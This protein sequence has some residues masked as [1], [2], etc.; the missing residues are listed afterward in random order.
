MRLE[1]TIA[2]DDRPLRR[3]LRGIEGEV[4]ASSK[5][6]ARD[7]TKLGGEKA[8]DAHVRAHIRELQRREAAE[9][10]AADRTAKYW[11]DAH[12]RAADH[13]IREEARA[14]R[15]R[16]REARRSTRIAAREREELSQ[17]MR[18]GIARTAVGSVGAVARMGGMALGL[19]GG[20]AAAG[21]LDQEL[22]INRR[23]TQLSISAGTPDQ[24]DALKREALAVR[25]FTGAETLSSMQGFVEKT[26]NLSAA[27]AMIQDMG[28]LA[29]ATSTDFGEMGMAAG[30]A[31]NVIRDTITDP[32]EQMK[33][34]NEVMRNLAAG[35][36]M[37]AVEI[38]DMVTELGGLGAAT[39][40]FEGG[41]V[42]LIKQA[43]AMAQASIAR[44]GAGTAP[45]TTTAVTRF[46]QDIVQNQKHFKAAG[47]EIFS[48]KNKTKLLGMEHIAA[49]VLEKTG[50]DLTK[51][52][53]MFGVYG[54][55]ALAGFSP[56]FIEAERKK[57]GSGRAAVAAEFSK[58]TGATLTDQQIKTNVDTRLADPDVQLKEAAKA[59]NTAVGQSLVPVAVDAAHKFAELAPQIGAMA[60]TVAK[61]V[62]FLVENPFA[63]VGVIVGGSIAKDIASAGLANIISGEIK[64]KLG[65][66]MNGVGLGLSVATMIVTAGILNFEK[67]EADIKAGGEGVNEARKLAKEGDVAAIDS[68]IQKQR[69]RATGA[70]KS[71]FGRTFAE[72]IGSFLTGSFLVPDGDKA[73]GDTGARLKARTQG[74]ADSFEKNVTDQ[75][76]EVDVKSQEQFLQDLMKLR[77]AAAAA[78]LELAK[79]KSNDTTGS[80]A[81]ARNGPINT[82]S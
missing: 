52:N 43:A 23:A 6:T 37:G 36:N 26:G 7:S 60:R 3:T 68:L 1:Y 72:V 54:E 63:G 18:G 50:G 75:N 5:R 16:E 65:A 53:A 76:R 51:I 64:G 13:R 57:K 45:E 71:G 48:D 9:R 12:R 20:F 30:Q 61:F 19:A 79:V 38:K 73:L 25:G 29:L 27:R 14:E 78:A 8:Q 17:R 70:G 35:G 77:D 55:R 74:F 21:A 69:E 4:R 67:R 33:A 82:R 44:G 39:R 10:R 11:Q 2:A 47:V 15:A 40:K 22:E 34:L 28:R 80:G 42:E 24:R 59:F 81:A 62:G 41:P 56:L 32:K 58:F 49:N 66:A 46:A 31:F